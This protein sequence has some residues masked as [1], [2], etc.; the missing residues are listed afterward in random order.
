MLRTIRQ[1]CLRLLLLL[2]LLLLLPARN[3]SQPPSTASPPASAN[4]TTGEAADMFAQYR[5]I[6]HASIGPVCRE[7]SALI[8]AAGTRMRRLHADVA[9]R[10]LHTVAAAAATTAP[11]ST[12]PSLPAALQR[13]QHQLSGAVR[14]MTRTTARSLRRLRRLFGRT[15]RAIEAAIGT[16]ADNEAGQVNRILGHA[17]RSAHRRL[18]ATMRR[19]EAHFD[20]GRRAID[21]LRASVEGGAELLPAEVASTVGAQ[22]LQ[23]GADIGRVRRLTVAGV[24]TVLQRLRHAFDVLHEFADDV[25]QL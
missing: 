7:V 20:D 3:A 6:A 14:R 22:L 12:H 9:A 11:N 15:E 21:G 23:T 16:G 17:E 13:S 2:L 19:I 4:H 10:M 24:G 25:E 1:R 5:R 8:R 18:A